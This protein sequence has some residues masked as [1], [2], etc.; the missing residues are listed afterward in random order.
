[1]DPITQSCPFDAE[2]RA[3]RCESC[4]TT[5]GELTPC[6]KA[7]LRATTVAAQLEPLQMA[8]HRR[9]AERIAA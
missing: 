2:T 8:A 5:N 3:A 4:C 7:W 9:L 1:M 6:V